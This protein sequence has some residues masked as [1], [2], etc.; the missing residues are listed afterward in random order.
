VKDPAGRF[1]SAA[2]VADLLEQHLAHLDDPALPPPAGAF[3]GAEAV[4][5]PPAVSAGSKAAPSPNKRA[6]PR[7]KWAAAAALLLPFLALTL[8]ETA[9]ITHVFRGGGAPTESNQPGSKPTS[10]E[11]TPED[12]PHAVAP[13]DPARPEKP[14]TPGQQEPPAKE[15]A[16]IPA[17]PEENP[18]KKVKVGDWAEYKMTQVANGRTIDGKIRMEVTGKTETTAKLKTI[19]T[20]FA[21]GMAS[22]EQEIDLSKPYDPTITLFLGA[23]AKVEKVDGGAEKL[24]VG[25]KEYETSWA[26]VKVTAKV[27]GRDLEADL[28][29][30]TSASAPLG[31]LVKIETTN[32]LKNA[33]NRTESKTTMELTGSG[34]KTHLIEARSYAA[35]GDWSAAAAAYARYFAVQPL[36]DGEVGFEYA[37]VL[38]MSGDEPGYRKVCAE[39]LEHSGQ[40]SIRPYHVA[41]AWTLAPDSVKDTALAGQRAD[42]ELK[43]NNWAFWSLTE[44]GALAYRAGRYDEAATLLEQSLKADSRPGRAV[45]NW[46]WLA[47]VEERRGK[48]AAAL[49]WLEK[50][51]KWLEQ[52]PTTSVVPDDAKGTH[53]HNWTEAQVLRREAERALALAKRAAEKSK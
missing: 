36:E 53:L 6:R 40:R 52:Y 28:K 48:P 15:A 18:F 34:S 27:N 45:L 2:A 3:A 47:L 9:G 25:G 22:P 41:R 51:T 11:A 12:P 44:R 7:W 24:K 19:T 31:G 50:A 16:A 4:E 23:N 46:L 26:K 37:T 38:L 30:W 33:A 14:P 1:Q 29:Y 10:P 39:M 35:R 49:A 17:A 32:V 42:T 20:V 43:Q 21:Q 5:Q 8:A 13:L